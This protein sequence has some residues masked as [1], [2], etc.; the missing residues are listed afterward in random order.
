MIHGADD[1]DGA[2]Y[3]GRGKPPP[4]KHFSWIEPFL[5]KLRETRSV[6]KACQSVHISR[7]RA[8]AY[9]DSN[10][11]FR[12]RWDEIIQTCIDDLEASA[13]KRAI[14]GNPK[15]L[16]HKGQPIMVRA[17]DGTMQPLIVRDYETALTIFMLKALRPKTYF[18]E[19]QLEIT[20]SAALLNARRIRDAR[21]QIE[22]MV[23]DVV[24][25]AGGS[26]DQVGAV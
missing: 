25:A 15:P 22:N 5:V 20:E 8:Y 2:E 4:A 11:E 10:S 18:L 19:K 13:L 3:G 17:T 12:E 16:L 23:P 26:D 7:T 6:S 24:A 14:E 1:G 21:A 9:R